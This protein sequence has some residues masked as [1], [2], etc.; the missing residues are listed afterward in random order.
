MTDKKKLSMQIG[1]MSVNSLNTIEPNYKTIENND[2]WAKTITKGSPKRNAKK[3]TLMTILFFCGLIL[4]STV[5]NETRNVQKEINK[6][7]TNL[8][9]IQFNL[10]SI[11]M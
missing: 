9:S 8:N 6:L 11:Q 2:N 4:V 5:K 7:Q 3:Y 1:M 10:I